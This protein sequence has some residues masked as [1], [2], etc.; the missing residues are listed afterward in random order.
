MA[1]QHQ[2]GRGSKGGRAAISRIAAKQLLQARIAEISPQGPPHRLMRGGLPHRAQVGEPNAG[3]QFDRVGS[4]AG[5]KRASQ[6]LV[7]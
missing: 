6:G 2:S 1:D 3:N 7:D 5:D 4:L